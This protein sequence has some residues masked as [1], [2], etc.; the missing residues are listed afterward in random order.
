M[1]M[2]G[3]RDS[4]APSPRPARGTKART[5][6]AG[7]GDTLWPVGPHVERVRARANKRRTGHASVAVIPSARWR[8]MRRVAG[9]PWKEDGTERL[10]ASDD[11]V[12]V[13]EEPIQEDP[14]SR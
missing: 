3:Q 11:W 9:V 14:A 1:A 13:E 10:D 6:G 7:A 8:P 12:L 2:P 5:H 4:T